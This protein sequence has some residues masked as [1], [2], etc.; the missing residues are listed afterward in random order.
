MNIT[1]GAV[2]SCSEK[3]EKI[4]FTV[5]HNRCLKV[6]FDY[7]GGTAKVVVKANEKISDLTDDPLNY[8]KSRM[9]SVIERCEGDN[10]EK[11][12][13]FKALLNSETKKAFVKILDDSFIR[14]V[15]KEHIEEFFNV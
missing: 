1:D 3:G 15:R 10:I 7:F 5:T 4:E 13:L 2:V 9:L 12:N 6:A 14:E 11:E 8:A